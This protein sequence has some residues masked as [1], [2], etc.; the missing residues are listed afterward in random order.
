MASQTATTAQPS[1]L[2]FDPVELPPGH[3][4]LRAEIRAFIETERAAGT[5]FGGDWSIR[6][7]AGFSR[8]LGAAGYIGMTWPKQYG[9][10]E[11]SA[12]E[13]YVVTEE[14][15]AAGAPVGSHWTADRQSGPLIL[16]VGSEELRRRI[17]PR[18]AKGECFFCIGMSEPDSG[19]D[20]ASI[21]TTATP[22]DGGWLINGTKLWTSGAHLADYMIALVRTA[23]PSED[24]HA[25]MSQMLIDL[26]N[27][28]GIAIRPIRNLAGDQ[29]FN[30]EVF[31]DCFVP[32]DMVVGEVGQGWAQV[33]SELGYERSGPERF[34]SSFQVFVELVRAVGP[35]PS[36]RAAEVIGRLAAHIMTLR[37]MSL[38]V[39]GMLQ[40]GMSPAVEAA[41]VKDMGTNFAKAMPEVARTL[42]QGEGL[43]VGEA[44]ETAITDTILYA[45]SFT[46]QGGTREILRGV[47]ARGLGLR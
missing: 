29:H 10:H 16:R 9:G 6:Y 35:D 31:T 44:L 39:A 1:G 15:L 17:L 47:V 27:S 30:E 33:V 11:R 42:S 7:D 45:P 23:P 8:R 21:R 28:P 26:K 13:R 24:R 36:P 4:D 25:G 32:D 19:S 20:L 38:S 22:T 12:L 41:V 18:V 40:S 34:L 43:D 3:Q 37:S 2:R 14:L 5:S 46:I